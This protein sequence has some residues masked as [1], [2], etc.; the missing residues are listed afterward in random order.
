MKTMDANNDGILDAADSGFSTLKV[1]VDDD[2]DGTTDSGE[3][4]TLTT[5]VL[6]ASI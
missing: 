4:K 1:W 3:S 6:K 2:G 5:L